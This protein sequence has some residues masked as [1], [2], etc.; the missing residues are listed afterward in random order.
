MKN[1]F[2]LENSLIDCAMI[3]VTFDT[4]DMFSVDDPIRAEMFTMISDA[5]GSLMRFLFD[6]CDDVLTRPETLDFN[7]EAFK[8]NTLELMQRGYPGHS[9]DRMMKTDAFLPQENEL[10]Y[11][12][13]AGTRSLGELESMPAPQFA[14]LLL[15]EVADSVNTEANYKNKQTFHRNVFKKCLGFLFLQYAAR[16]PLFYKINIKF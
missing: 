1:Q 8:T 10:Y 2:A 12:P 4:L 14:A 6:R 5:R 13:L 16:D 11:F 9:L 15:C 7:F 3:R